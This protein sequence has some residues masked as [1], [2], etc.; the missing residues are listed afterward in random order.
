MNILNGK[1]EKEQQSF[2]SALIGEKSI[3]NLFFKE[4]DTFIFFVC[5][6]RMPTNITKMYHLG[7]YSKYEH[8]IIF[9]DSN[10]ID[11]SALYSLNEVERKTQRYFE[12]TL[13]ELRK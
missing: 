13:K 2:F 10:V 11:F 12:Y 7:C 8:E 9:E 6:S 5:Y 3:F 1:T 4:N